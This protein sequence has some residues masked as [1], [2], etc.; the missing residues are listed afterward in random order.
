VK[1]STAGAAVAAASM[2]V[3]G[4]LAAPG[5]AFAIVY[6]LES[7][8]GGGGSAA[9]T[10]LFS[11]EENGSTVT[12]IADVMVGADDIL[13]DAL[14]QSPIHGLRAY[15]LI[16]A[17]SQLISINPTTGAAAH[18]GSALANRTMRA[19]AFDALGRLW[20]IDA[21]NNVLLRIDPVTGAVLGSPVPLLLGIDPFA[22][23]SAGSDIAFAANGSGVLVDSNSVYSL[24]VA[25]GAV[26][27][28]FQDTAAQM[29]LSPVFHVGAAFVAGV[30][31]GKLFVFDVNG[32]DDVYF[33]QS[34]STPRVLY[35][36]DFSPAFNSGRGDLASLPPIL[37]P[38]QVQ[39]EFKQDAPAPGFGGGYSLSGIVEPPS[40][41]DGGYLVFRAQ[42][43]GPGSD[44]PQVV[45]RWHPVGGAVLIARTGQSVGCPGATR[46]VDFLESPVVDNDGNVAFT[47]TLD[48]GRGL[49][50]WDATPGTL[51]CAARTGQAVT[52]TCDTIAGPCGDGGVG[53]SVGGLLT[54]IAAFQNRVAAS[55]SDG[56][57]LFVG[58]MS[59]NAGGTANAVWT[60]DLAT[61][62]LVNIANSRQLADDVVVPPNNPF[63]QTFTHVASCDGKLYGIL[64]VSQGAP[65]SVYELKPD[66]QNHDSLER[67]YR[68]EFITRVDFHCSRGNWGYAG[69][70][71][72]IQNDL[73]TSRRGVWV[74]NQQI[75]SFG[76][77]AFPGGAATTL[78]NQLGEAL[79]GVAP[80][81]YKT[82][83]A[84]KLTG[85][86]AN[87]KSGVFIDGSAIALQDVAYETEAHPGLNLSIEKIYTASVSPPGNVALFMQKRDS[88]TMA[89]S[90]ALAFW[91]GAAVSLFSMVGDSIQV[92]G[93]PAT[94]TGF[95]VAGRNF[96][97]T[98]VT[99]TGRD[100][101]INPFNDSNTFVYVVD[102][103]LQS[104][105]GQSPGGGLVP[106]GGAPGSA[107]AIANLNQA[108]FASLDVDAN[109]VVQPLTDG[110]LLLRHLFGFTGATL[111]NGA[112]G[113]G[114][115]RCAAAD[116][117][118]YLNGLGSLLN[119]DGN[120]TLE[121][122]T[123]G[124][125][126]L[127]YL[128]GFTGA[129]LT[130]GAVGPMCTRC[131]SA[132][133]VGY[134]DGLD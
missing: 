125:L 41:I 14:A 3:L 103:V 83:F 131:D 28:L 89:L 124:L 129:T 126:A 76:V 20:V 24:N 40:I 43:D 116:I 97:D 73:D 81:D 47:A 5:T 26:A 69:T 25:N 44:D 9:P 55:F 72:S 11:F 21:A 71:S 87:G 120:P 51:I 57:A 113:A 10:Q 86:T 23:T 31:G 33:Y 54:N 111:I 107:I 132:A 56:R 64:D 106:R 121:A 16:G 58:A 34:L 2:A 15:R 74:D 112:L 37:A 63:Y 36:E 12:V 35:D 98:V 4:A 88:S 82:V 6:G 109:G 118:T 110:L 105:L 8:E 32:T 62:T 102:Y 101:H 68:S 1:F 70:F 29:D 61:G 60:W 22:I 127:R 133:I 38:E 128:F 117:T 65:A 104:G 85:G 19:A 91:D 77:T 115:S 17:N 67:G 99:G 75:Y 66:G 95:R 122:L 59:V 53:N 49:L 7:N 46:T 93:E 84:T 13:A 30:G 119:V 130:T 134:L 27:L 123:D 52:V 45:Y 79:L 96:T 78:G 90:D 108:A 80:G 48:T 39:F 92:G 42:V 100:G 114:C 94:I 18:I 50:V